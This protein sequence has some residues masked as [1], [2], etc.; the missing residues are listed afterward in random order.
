MDRRD[1]PRAAVAAGGAPSSAGL[2]TAA[3]AASTTPPTIRDIVYRRWT[4]PADF[5]AG[6]SV[7]VTVTDDALTIAGPVGQLTYADP[8]KGTTATYEYATWTSPW[9]YPGFAA[10]EVVPSWTAD[11]P[12]GTWIQVEARGVTALGTTTRW[13]NLGRWA[14][15]DAQIFRTSQRAQRDEDGSVAVDT[16]VAAEGRGWTAYELRVTLLRP[17]GTAQSP[18]V[19]SVGAMASRLPEKDKP[20]PTAPQAARGVVLDVPRYSQE[21]HKGHYPQW[22][23]GGEAWCSPTSTSMVLSYWGTGPTPEEYAWVEPSP[24]PWVDYAAR[25]TYDYSYA[26]CGNWPFNTAYA[27]RWG[28][29]AFVTRLR[30]LNE[31]E[32]FIAA[33]IPLVVSASFTKNQIPGLTYGTGGHLMCLVGFTADGQ[34]VM[35]DPFSP[36]NEDVRKTVGRAEFEAAWLTTSRGIVYVIHPPSVALPDAPRQ[37]NW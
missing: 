13:Y 35:N 27:G 15:D 24:D 18:A 29:E 22:D 33:G 37:A 19:R 7:G 3:H 25:H 36:T 31:A 20:V 4:T 5:A 30:S 2:A 28:L 9:V 1:T 12:G 16:F 21:A 32:L 14:A 10:T 11:T 26:G 23:N 8:Y 17:V 6:T 34:P